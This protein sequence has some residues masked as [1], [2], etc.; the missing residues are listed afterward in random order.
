[1]R[2]IQA[3][4]IAIQRDGTTG[5]GIVRFHAALCEMT[6]HRGIRDEISRYEG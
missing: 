6:G 5:D 4:D 1:L 2:T 3:N